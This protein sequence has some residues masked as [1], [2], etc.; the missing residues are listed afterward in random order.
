MKV[1]QRIIAILAS[2]IVAIG[3]AS[4]HKAHAATYTEQSLNIR[5]DDITLAGHLYIPRNHD[6]KMPAVILSH[7]LGGTYTEVE[8]YARSLAR[9][10]YLTYAYD[11]AGG[12]S[13]SASRGRSTR[14]MSIFTEEKDLSAVLNNIRQRD[15]VDPNRVSLVGASQGGVV[16]ALTASDHQSEVHSL[17]LLYPA[18]SASADAKSRYNSID[19]VPS[20]VNLLGVEVGRTYYRRLLKTNVMNAATKYNGPTIIIHGSAD[21]I[22]PVRYARQAVKK[23]PHAQLRIIKGADHGFPGN[24]QRQ[25]IRVLNQFFAKYGK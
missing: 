11:F 23:F 6:N 5:Y 2:L 8:P 9:Q 7:G 1:N 10:G 16:S 22:V 4:F 15:D 12:S 18:F 14:Q 25:A 20:S 13:A 3:L 17:G 21:S 19:E 24:T